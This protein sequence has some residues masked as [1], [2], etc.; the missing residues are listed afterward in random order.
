MGAAVPRDTL[1]VRTV[2][3]ALAVRGE[4]QPGELVREAPAALVLPGRAQAL[5]VTV[6]L[7]VTVPRQHLELRGD[8]VLV[9][10]DQP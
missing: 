7:Q 8:E 5:T 1:A 3:W 6:R 10:G 4:L 2:R 9:G